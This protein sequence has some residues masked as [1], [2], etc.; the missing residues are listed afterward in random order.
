MIF[1]ASS[2][3]SGVANSANKAQ[4]ELVS[5]QQTIPSPDDVLSAAFTEEVCAQAFLQLFCSAGV[6]FQLWGEGAYRSF[7]FMFN[8]LRISPLYG[9]MATTS[10][11]DTLWR[12]CLDTGN[13]TVANQA[14]SDL[15]TIYVADSA[16]WQSLSPSDRM[17]SESP[18]QTLS[19][20]HI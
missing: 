9:K 3:G 19:L 10:A 11:L 2:S 18:Q 12:I 14:M 20:I 8:K 16:S 15:L 6:S 17:D 1:I 7:Q 4:E 13:D 5:A